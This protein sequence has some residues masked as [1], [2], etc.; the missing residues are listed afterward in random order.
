MHNINVNGED[1]LKRQL[2]LAEA[3]RRLLSEQQVTAISIMGAIGSG[4]TSLIERMI[5]RL[6][7]RGCHV[8]TIAA[9]SAGDDD[10][11]RFVSHGAVSIN[12]NTQDD[13]H[14]D[15]HRVDHA[16]DHLP[17]E[18]LDVLFIENVGNLICPADFPLGT[19]KEMV[20][21][22]TTEGDDMVRKHPKIFA[23]TDILVLN[24]ID[25]ADAVGVDPERILSD[26]ARINPHGRI[27]C[28]D[29][30]HDK[31][32]DELLDALGLQCTNTP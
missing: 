19:A 3:N 22:S 2:E 30:R 16:M 29:A 8:G 12:L 4:K 25:L 7:S 26:Y 18:L 13:C 15:A 21:I 24:K 5:D 28:T 20:V 14:L 9:D 11:Q 23:Q 31:G 1:I 27:V 10:H 32:I 6:T 17:M